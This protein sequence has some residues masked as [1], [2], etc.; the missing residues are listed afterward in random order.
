MFTYTMQDVASEQQQQPV[1]V[2]NMNKK[3]KTKY[4]PG[5]TATPAG[6]SALPAGGSVRRS[7]W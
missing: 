5:S 2:N 3:I 6:S 4:H 7:A 1:A